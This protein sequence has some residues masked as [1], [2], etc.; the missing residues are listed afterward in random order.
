LAYWGASDTKPED[1]F[2]MNFKLESLTFPLE[3]TLLEE[4]IWEPDV[5]FIDEK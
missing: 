2:G 4:G 5:I 3:M 1:S